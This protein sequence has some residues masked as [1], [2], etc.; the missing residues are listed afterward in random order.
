M[1]FNL[2]VMLTQVG[3]A[4]LTSL[5]NQLQ[6][7]K[8]QKTEIWIKFGDSLNFEIVSL[9]SLTTF[10]LAFANKVRIQCSEIEDLLE[11]VLRKYPEEIQRLKVN[12]PD[13]QN[14]YQVFANNGLTFCCQVLANKYEVN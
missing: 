5:F 11:A 3:L 8:L 13:R 12:D 4:Q 1:N 9:E 10:L 6:P 14:I 7:I 2:E